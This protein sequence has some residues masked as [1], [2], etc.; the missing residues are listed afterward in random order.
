MAETAHPAVVPAGRTWAPAAI[1]IHTALI[2]AVAVFLHPTP[3]YFVET[4]LVGEYIPAA[5]DLLAGHVTPERFAF[6]G[7]G[8]PLMLAAMSIPCGGDFYL[9]ARVL[10]ALS[11]GVAAALAFRLILCWASAPVA[12]FALLAL[13]ANPTFVR[14]GIEAGTDM[15]SLALM[16]AATVLL[17]SVPGR[18]GALAAGVATGLA[19]VTRYNAA[20]LVPA[21]LLVLLLRPGRLRHAGAFVAGLLATLGLWLF[22]NARIGSGALRNSNYLNI[23]FELYGR[24]LPWDRFE[25][26]IG[27]RFQSLGDVLRFDP[28]TA[29]ARIARN[30][31]AHFFTDLFQLVPWWIGALSGPGLVLS[32]RRPGWRMPLVFF[33]LCSLALAPVFYS[34]RFSLYLLPFH[35]AAAGALLFELDGLYAAWRQS[36]PSWRWWR[37]ATRIAA[38]AAV[39][40]SLAFAVKEMAWHLSRAPHE[41]RLAGRFLRDQGYTGRIMARKPHVAYFAGMTQ[42]A[43]GPTSSLYELLAKARESGASYLFFSP[44][45]QMLR[46]EYAVL[47]DSGLSLPGLHPIAYRSLGDWRYYAIYRVD[48]MPPDSVA[49]ARA[50]VDAVIVHADRHRNDAAA[51]VFAAFQ[52]TQAGRPQ[53][54]VDRLLPLQRAGARDGNVYAILSTAYFALGQ[55]DSSFAACERSMQLMEPIAWHHV[56]LASIHELRGRYAEA[57]DQYLLALQLEPGSAVTLERLGL[58]YMALQEPAK[59]APLFERCVR[60][61]PLNPTLRRYAIGAWQMA[62]NAQRARS[63]LDEGV[64]AG[65]PLRQLL[66]TEA[67]GAPGTPG[68]P[69]APGAP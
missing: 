45:E 28:P 37:P 59:A 40:A 64:R 48:P 52:L 32:L 5:R 60:L 25:A 50:F 62:G 31:V 14:Y 69:G 10:G 66:G 36:P 33:V 39:V 26:E 13:L 49:L 22:V 11:S 67:P 41:T 23:A 29:A 6:K 2:L 15:P 17:L 20:F 56:R 54:A 58:M 16:L 47:G 7:P 4:D 3:L 21:G 53:E 35:L 44:I 46:G 38:V 9:A 30:L 43:M 57:R 27:S 18:R 61:S 63:L 42:V 24:D 55:A 68:V 8:Y 65:I 19:V 51:Q 12:G 1:V 34:P